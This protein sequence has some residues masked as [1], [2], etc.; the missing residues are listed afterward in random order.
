MG[1]APMESLIGYTTNF[2]IQ[3]TTNIYDGQ[4]PAAKD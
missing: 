3:F 2:Q 4:A 1:Y